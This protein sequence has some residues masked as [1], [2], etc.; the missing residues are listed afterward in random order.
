MKLMPK[1]LC[2]NQNDYPEGSITYAI[3]AI[4]DRP[5]VADILAQKA[6]LHIPLLEKIDVMSQQY[7]FAQEASAHCVFDNISAED[8]QNTYPS[9]HSMRATVNAMIPRIAYVRGKLRNSTLFINDRQ[10][11]IYL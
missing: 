10:S 1:Y 2:I 4:H 8:G 9:E 6:Q 11:N 5:F 7:Q 3:Q